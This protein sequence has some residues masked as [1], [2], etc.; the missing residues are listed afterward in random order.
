MSARR[1]AEVFRLEFSHN[2]RRPLFWILLLLVGF[3]SQQL[4]IGQA[5]VGSGNSAVGGTKAWITS[6]FAVAQLLAILVTACYGFFVSVAAGLSVV[7]D[8]DHKVG[9]VLHST[10]LTPAEYIWGKF[11]A[12]FASFVV[13]LCLHMAMSAFFNHALPK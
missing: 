13:V 12:V 1:F 10:P 6:E 7:H 4:S 11:S 5:S 2:A 8:S 3:L 9:E